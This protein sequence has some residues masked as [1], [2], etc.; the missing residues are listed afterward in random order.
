[1]SKEIISAPEAGVPVGPYSQAV[2]SG[3]R[4]FLSAEKGVDPAT[5]KVAD[6][7]VR[8]QT[9][10]V[11]KNIGTILKAAGASI[12]HVVRCVVYLQNIEDFPAM[13]DAYATVFTSQP[14]ARTTVGVAALPLGLSVMI[15]ATAIRA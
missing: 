3:N 15:E 13:S 6:G 12:E 5:G 4:I 11:L 9:L 2:V 7:G 1:M 14:P 8:G 10:Q